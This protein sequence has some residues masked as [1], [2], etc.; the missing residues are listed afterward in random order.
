[1]ISSA[2]CNMYEV[3]ARSALAVYGD[4]VRT[5]GGTL[6]ASIC[7]HEI[8]D[9]TKA[10][11]EKSM[12]ALGYGENACAHIAVKVDGSELGAADVHNVI[13]AI[14]P[15]AIVVCDEEAAQ[16]VSHAYRRPVELDAS[17][18]VLG[19]TVIAFRD[20]ER[21]MGSAKEKQ[22]AWALLKKIPHLG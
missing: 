8:D 7:S 4:F 15:L 16:V 19:R 20:L 17:T 13:E 10:A 18:R 12:A 11:V 1:M 5:Q 3:N 9:V 14:D 22:R 2:N 21:M 6:V